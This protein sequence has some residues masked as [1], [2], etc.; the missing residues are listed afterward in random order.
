MAKYFTYFTNT[1][2]TYDGTNSQFVTNLLSKVSFE[3]DF[4]SYFPVSVNKV[5]QSKE[6]PTLVN[7][8]K[9]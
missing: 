8:L 9:N 7:L 1:S 5:L 3:R 4:K 2:F 6:H